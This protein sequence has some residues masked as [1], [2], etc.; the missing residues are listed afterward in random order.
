MFDIIKKIISFFKLLIMSIFIIPDS[1]LIIITT[2]EVVKLMTSTDGGFVQLSLLWRPKRGGSEGWPKAMVVKAIRGYGM[3]SWRLLLYY[4]SK[5]LDFHLQEKSNL[6]YF[7]S[8]YLR[9]NYKKMSGNILLGSGVLSSGKIPSCE[10]IRAVKS[11][12]IAQ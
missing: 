8:L 3:F 10:Q 4:F 1:F 12:K 7:A 11:K 6:F 9:Q 2:S 5:H